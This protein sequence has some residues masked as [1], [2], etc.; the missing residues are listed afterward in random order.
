VTAQY[1]VPTPIPLSDFKLVAIV[2]TDP[3]AVAVQHGA[4]WKT[5]KDLV[6][7]ARK[8]PG[9]LRL[10]MIPGASA[11][12]FAAGLENAAGIETIQVPFKGDSDGAIALAGGHI[13]I[14]VAVPV[15]YKTLE[16]AKKVRML[17]VA[18]RARSPLYGNLPTF[19]ENGVDLV[20][21]AF[22]GVYVP[23]GDKLADALAKTMASKELHA[24]MD[25]AGAGI[26]FLRGTEA[27]T[28]LARQ[29]ETYR[30]IIDKLGLRVSPK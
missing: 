23:K 16:A 30:A 25:N 7:D 29:D 26:A 6:E 14:H 4:P 24:G 27:N 3:A 13:D 15:S 21:G 1:T 22:H 12:I 11:Q 8:Q 20:I 18:D 10:G 28:Y 5:L 9:K 19:K 17:A 2:N